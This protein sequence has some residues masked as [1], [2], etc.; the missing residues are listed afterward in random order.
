MITTRGH[1]MLAHGGGGQMTDDLLS[2]AVLPRLNNPMLGELLDSGILPSVGQD[3]LAL[4]IDGYVVQPW[5]F[6]GGDIGRLAV[7]GTVND[8]AVCGAVPMGLALG[9]IVSEGFA[10]GDIEAILDSIAQAAEEAGVKVV[11][12]DTKVV[13]R[14]SGEDIFITT[15]GIGRVP[16]GRRLSPDLVRPGNKI[17]INGPIGEHGLTVMLAREMA[18]V[19]STLISDV[20]PLNGLIS[21]LLHLAPDVVFMRDPTRAGLAGVAVDLAQRGGWRVMLEESAIPVRPVAEHAAEMLGLD[22]LE[23]ANEGKVVVVVRPEDAERALGAMRSHPLGRGAAVIGEIGDV[24][25]GMC[26]LR[27]DIGGRRVVQKPYGEQLP[28]I[29]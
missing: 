14:G 15:A 19:R 27:T 25:D 5:R 24:A 8:L 22:V 28:R 29:C 13:N 2:Q 23:V 10:V 20:A 21:H 3:K 11:T 4:T 6:P 26:E 7:C 12:G 18:E 16:M 9:L 17:L 1:I